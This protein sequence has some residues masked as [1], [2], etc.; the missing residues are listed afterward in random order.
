MIIGVTINI[1]IVEF[2]ADRIL[3]LQSAQKVIA[4]DFDELA[5]DEIKARRKL[6]GTQLSGFPI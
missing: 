1:Q 2:C 5:V 3:G 6:A 4:Y